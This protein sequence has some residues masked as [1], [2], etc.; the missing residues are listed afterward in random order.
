MDNSA[1]LDIRCD[2]CG[3]V[4][5]DH[6]FEVARTK[7]RMH[8]DTA[9]GIPEAEVADADTVA[10]FCSE[11]CLQSSVQEVLRRRGIALLP[12]GPG[13]GPIETCG[14]CRGVVDRSHWHFSY[15]TAEMRFSGHCGT[16]SGVVEHAVTCATCEG[17]ATRASTED[18]TQLVS[19]PVDVATTSPPLLAQA[20][21]SMALSNVA[22]IAWSGVGSGALTS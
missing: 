14:I 20:P 15:T 21:P 12:E 22:G 2:M 11:A 10:G 1:P 8:Y 3:T 18:A 6:M 19:G 13:V 16:A 4:T 7:E 5:Y 17:S 9:H